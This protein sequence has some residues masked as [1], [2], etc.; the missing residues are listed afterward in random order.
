M[1]GCA[2]APLH[3]VPIPAPR[4]PP[5]VLPFPL[6]RLPRGAVPHPRFAASLPKNSGHGGVKPAP[7][8]ETLQRPSLTRAPRGCLCVTTALLILS[9]LS[10]L[11]LLPQLFTA[12]FS[13]SCRARQA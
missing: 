10:L 6:L 1:G 13:L 2:A 3:R 9:F 4:L 12:V 7:R 11:S 5:Q 8:P